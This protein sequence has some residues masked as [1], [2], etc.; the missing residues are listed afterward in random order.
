MKIRYEELSDVKMSIGS[1]RQNAVRGF[2]AVTNAI[3]TLDDN[4]KI[5][6]TGWD[7]TITHLEAYKEIDKTMFNVYYEMENSLGSY[8][9]DFV[10]EVEQIDEMLDTSKLGD[11]YRELQVAQTDYFNLM[12]HLAEAMKDVPVLGDWFKQ[13]STQPIQ[14]KIEILQKYEAF[15]SSHA[16]HYSVLS[17][18]IADVNAG[19]ARLGDPANFI[20]P[21]KGYQAI[22]YSQEK[23]YKNL[24]DFNNSQPEQRIETFSRVDEH[25]NIIYVVLKNGVEDKELS[26]KMT[27]AMEDSWLDKSIDAV[28]RFLD[29]VGNVVKTTLGVVT[30][31][32]GIVGTIG[33]CAV[34]TLA[35]GGVGILVD[36]VIVTEGI[37]V[38]TTGIAITIDGINGLTT[39]NFA[40]NG[41]AGEERSLKTIRGNKSANEQ[42]QKQGYDDAHDFKQTFVQKSDISKFDMLWDSKTGEIFLKSKKGNIL[43][44]TGHFFIK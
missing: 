25:G 39:S 8:L 15:E 40:S 32:T 43:I 16:S 13:E 33:G 9:T 19:L 14:D 6:G 36:G 10:I 27:E 1:E 3:Q 37:V 34:V 35:T 26:A 12:S 5:K 20:S 7:S 41:G 4:D 23:W 2:N 22:D 17:S 24:K 31:I 42:A 38:T 18:L 29:I 11:L 44:E 30:T 28:S 21:Q